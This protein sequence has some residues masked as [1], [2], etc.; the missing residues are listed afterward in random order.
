MFTQCQCCGFRFEVDIVQLRATY[1]LVNCGQCGK[2]FNAADGL[3]DEAISTSKMNTEDFQVNDSIHSRIDHVLNDELILLSEES[4]PEWGNIPVPNEEKRYVDE[5]SHMKTV[6]NEENN[7][8]PQHAVVLKS[9]V[10]QFVP[11][12]SSIENY[13]TKNEENVKEVELLLDNLIEEGGVEQVSKLKKQE[14]FTGNYQ[15]KNEENIKEVELLLDNLIEEEGE[16]VSELEIKEIFTENYQTK[17]EESVKEVELL[18]DSLI[19]EKGVDQVSELEVLESLLEAQNENVKKFSSLDTSESFLDKQSENGSEDVEKLSAR[20]DSNT[21]TW[22]VAIL[23]MIALLAFQY[24]YSARNQLAE[25]NGLRAPLETMCSVLGC[26]IPFKKSVNE[27]QLIY[28]SVQEHA[29]IKDA[30]VV[31]A[32]YVNKASFVQSYP[33]LELVFFNMEQHIVMKR[34]FYPYEYLLDK[35]NIEEGISPDVSIQALLEIVDPGRDVVNFE[36]NF[37]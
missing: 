26:R 7:S 16:Q 29:N 31:S 14:V 24:T 6:L 23:T 35:N 17:N 34:Q 25:H 32:T 10:H 11:S 9:V 30:L 13:Q 36:F 5:V 12:S 4:E 1:G 28:K 22:S 19:E 15:T 37:L 18:L 20:S 21:V 2:E 33:I 3:Y 27:I 8:S